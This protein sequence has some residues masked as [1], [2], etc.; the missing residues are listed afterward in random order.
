[1]RCTPSRRFHPVHIK[2]QNFISLED[3]QGVSIGKFGLG[4][5]PWQPFLSTLSRSS[6]LPVHGRDRTEKT[7]RPPVS[8]ANWIL[9][10]RNCISYRLHALLLCFGFVRSFSLLHVVSQVLISRFHKSSTNRSGRNI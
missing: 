8:S 3:H 1:M 4:A 10:I 9:L 6:V 5:F 7:W 2:T